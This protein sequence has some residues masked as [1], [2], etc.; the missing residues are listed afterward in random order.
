MSP[1]MVFLN[2]T[3]L[4]MLNELLMINIL[5]CVVRFQKLISHIVYLHNLYTTYNFIS[6]LSHWERIHFSAAQKNSEKS[7]LHANNVF[8]KALLHIIIIWSPIVWCCFHLEILWFLW[9]RVKR[10]FTNH[11]S[12]IY[13][14]KTD[15]YITFA[16]LKVMKVSYRHSE[17]I[18]V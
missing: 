16:F 7:F 10:V 8:D 18:R 2:Y 5:A 11:E 12:V 1:I 9:Q 17:F 3:R 4:S 6:L 14:L 15:V 13:L